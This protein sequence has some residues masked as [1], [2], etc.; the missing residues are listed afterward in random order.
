MMFSRQQIT[1]LDSSRVIHK[2]SFVQQESRSTGAIGD[3]LRSSGSSDRH[4]VQ[5][6][7]IIYDA[8]SFRIT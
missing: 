8:G 3:L 1:F 7:R 2:V 5:V 4:H 6:V